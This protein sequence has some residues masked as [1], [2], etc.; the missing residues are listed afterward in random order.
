MNPNY[1]REAK[2]IKIPVNPKYIINKRSTSNKN[3]SKNYDIFN[4]TNTYKI[5][6]NTSDID[7]S[8]NETTIESSVEPMKRITIYKKNSIRAK[9]TINIKKNNS[10]IF[11]NY[12]KFNKN[13]NNS[14]ILFRCTS[15]NAI[16]KKSS[17]KK[18]DYKRFGFYTLFHFNEVE[19][20]NYHVQKRG[21]VDFLIY[22]AICHDV[23]EKSVRLKF[24][25]FLKAW[26]LFKYGQQLYESVQTFNFLAGEELSGN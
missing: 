10:T 11:Q 22:E 5:I 18:N 19:G 16:F 20:E 17:I 6:Q 15:A 9:N 26:S 7:T 2:K 3:P 12:N 21:N 8:R 24:T 1:S 23:S 14:Q 25:D 4:K 13:N